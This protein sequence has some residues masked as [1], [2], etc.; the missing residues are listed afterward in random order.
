MTKSIT[1]LIN[2]IKQLS[3]V[4]DKGIVIL[5]DANFSF[6]YFIIKII[7]NRILVFYLQTDLQQVY[8]WQYVFNQQEHL[9]FKIICNY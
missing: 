9:N 5:Y 2:C 4:N 8:H 6:N 1:F 7:E 3:L